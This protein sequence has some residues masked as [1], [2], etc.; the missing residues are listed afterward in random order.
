M[1]SR[2][3]NGK[4][5]K[6]FLIYNGANKREKTPDKKEK[7]YKYEMKLRTFHKPYKENLLIA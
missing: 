1:N 2:K 6:R 3:I 4:G 7:I 5:G